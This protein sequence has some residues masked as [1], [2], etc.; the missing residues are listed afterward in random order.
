MVPQRHASLLCQRTTKPKSP[1][2]SK[3]KTSG[4]SKI[5]HSCSQQQKHIGRGFGDAERRDTGKTESHVDVLEREVGHRDSVGV[6]LQIGVG[7]EPST[8][9]GAPVRTNYRIV[10]FLDVATL[11][12]GA[13]GA[14]TVAER[15][16]IG[17]IV[18]LV[19]V[20]RRLRHGI[21]PIVEVVGLIGIPADVVARCEVV[22]REIKPISC[23]APA[24]LVIR[25]ASA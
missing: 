14:G 8:P 24:A 19:G 5:G 10:S 3:R 22:L 2:K 16:G 12:K 18:L 21:N 25:R 23:I 20:G 13:T 11:I 1:Q 15:A 6:L 17:Q 7:A 9:G 4:A